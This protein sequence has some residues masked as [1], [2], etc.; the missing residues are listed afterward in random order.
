MVRRKLNFVAALVPRQ[1]WTGNP[2]VVDQNIE[3]PIRFQKSIGKAI[4]GSRAG[5]RYHLRV[6]DFGQIGPGSFDV[7]GADDNGRSCFNVYSL[8]CFFLQTLVPQEGQQI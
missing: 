5:E 4:D 7:A 1:R 2:R 3:R 6:P 8:G